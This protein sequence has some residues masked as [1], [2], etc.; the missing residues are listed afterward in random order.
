MTVQELK[1][2][3]FESFEKDF[4]TLNKLFEELL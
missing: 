2:I 1:Q 3:E 4:R